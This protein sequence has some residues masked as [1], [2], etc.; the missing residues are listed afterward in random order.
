M[1][2]T[3][4]ERVAARIARPFAAGTAEPLMEMARDLIAMCRETKPLEWSDT[5][6][7][8]ATADGVDFFAYDHGFFVRGG[9]GRGVRISAARDLSAAKAAAEAHHA[10]RVRG[11]LK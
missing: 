8:H 3:L 2:E 10:E 11:M 9:G 4:E 7:S 1:T 6:P 5:N